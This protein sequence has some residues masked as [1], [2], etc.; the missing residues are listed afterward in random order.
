M[1][2]NPLAISIRSKKLEGRSLI[3]IQDDGPGIPPEN[4]K[5]IFTRNFSNKDS[6]SGSSLILAKELIEKMEGIITVQSDPY[7]GTFFTIELPQASKF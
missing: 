4:L 6:G 1:M 3:V 7:L 5:K 2:I